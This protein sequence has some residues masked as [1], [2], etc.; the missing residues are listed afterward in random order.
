MKHSRQS[1]QDH[2]SWTLEEL[3]DIANQ[4]LPEVS[5]KEKAHTRVREAVTPRLVR[6][7]TSLGMLD[8][9]LKEGREARYTYRHLLQLLLIR[10]LLAEGYGASAI[11][12]LAIARTNDELEALLQG[13]MQLTIAPVNSAPVN[14]ALA[15]LQQ[16]QQAA[17][18]APSPS[19]GAQ[20][21]D[22]QSGPS[23]AP[24]TSSVRPTMSPD[25]AFEQSCISP[26]LVDDLPPAA[27]VPW[28]RLEILPGLEIHIRQD[29][30]FPSSP[31][32]QHDLWERIR[33]LLLSFFSRSSGP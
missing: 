29:F 6:H 31:Q 17:R 8:E 26:A 20:K 3:V 2:S 12:G 27:P 7:Y 24:A 32:E 9:P 18:P 28:I 11:G 15:Y 25:S 19:A 10:R 33:Q 13:E 22:R 4:R 21:G 14:S 5:P 30:A 16:I 1:D 23:T